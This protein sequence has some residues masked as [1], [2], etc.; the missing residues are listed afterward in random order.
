MNIDDS[1]TISELKKNI[2]EFVSQ[3]DWK[4]YHN[5]KDISESI[6]IDAGKLLESFQW[7]SSENSIEYAKKNVDKIKEEVAEVIIY[8]F[9][10]ANA[11]DINIS[12]AVTE[13]LGKNLK[14]IH[15][16]TFLVSSH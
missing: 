10:L 4:K 13:K 3:I 15:A 12:N 14:K 8:C 6:S 5:P 1:T 11:L 7:T 9:I 16:C 2:E